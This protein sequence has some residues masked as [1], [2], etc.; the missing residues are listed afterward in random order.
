MSVMLRYT[1]TAF[2]LNGMMAYNFPVVAT[3]IGAAADLTAAMARKKERREEKY[4]IF[5]ASERQ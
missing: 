5:K 1:R 2:S 3:T 4:N